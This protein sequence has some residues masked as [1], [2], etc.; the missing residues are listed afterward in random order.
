MHL[1]D[2]HPGSDWRFAVVAGGKPS[3]THYETVEAFRAASLMAVTLE[4]GRTHQIR[5]H[6]SAIRHPCVGDTTYGAD[7]RL[8]ERLK[9]TRQWLH[10]KELGF[11]HPATGEW[12]EFASAYPDDLSSALRAVR[13]ASA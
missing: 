8:T 12:V 5:V 10:A 11:T 7:P 4:T 6:F 2:R 1:I 9:L 13:D 3:V